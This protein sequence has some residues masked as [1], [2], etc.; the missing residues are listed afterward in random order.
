MVKHDVQ[1]IGNSDD[2][3]N[4]QVYSLLPT[5]TIILVKNINKNSLCR[6]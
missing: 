6:N 1:K 5:I 4:T 3:V 2:K